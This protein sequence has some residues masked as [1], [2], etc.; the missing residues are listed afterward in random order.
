MDI[1]KI[2]F[3]TLVFSV[4]CPICVSADSN[5]VDNQGESPTIIKTVVLHRKGNQRRPN[6]PSREKLECIYGEGFVELIFPEATEYVNVSIHSI[7]EEYSGIISSE[8]P[9]FHFPPILGECTIDCIT[10]DGKTF[11]GVL[12]FE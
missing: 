1:L 3:L 4:A 9:I 7:G 5:E 11:V 12:L 10:D 2:L 8:D 6:A